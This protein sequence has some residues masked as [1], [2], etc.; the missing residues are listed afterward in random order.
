MTPDVNV[1]V[2]AFRPDHPHHTPARAWLDDAVQQAAFNHTPLVLLGMVRPAQ[3]DGPSIGRFEPLAAVGS[4]THVRA[5]D[6]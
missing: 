6:R 2:A 5:F 4:A 1:L 3:T